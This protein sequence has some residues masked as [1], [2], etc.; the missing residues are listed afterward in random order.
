MTDAIASMSDSPPHRS[1]PAPAVTVIA[2]CYNHARFLMAC[3]ESIRAQT[4]QDFQLIVTDDC[5]KDDSP[6]MIAAWLAEFYPHAIFIRHAKNAGICATLNEAV[7]LAQGHFISMIATDDTWQ[8]HKIAAQ[9]AVAMA[10][11]ENTAVVYSDALQMDEE[12]ALLEGTFIGSHKKNF[13]APGGAVFRQLADGNFIPAMA[14]L[15][16]TSA[17]RAV[18][19]YDERLSYEDYD[20]WLRLANRYDFVFLPGTVASYRIVATSIVRTL[21]EKPTPRHSYSRFLIHEKWLATDRL[22][23]SQ[24]TIWGEKL[25]DSAYSLYALDDPRAGNCLWKAFFATRKL[26]PL[27]LAGTTSLGLNR[28]RA[29]RMARLFRPTDA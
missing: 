10:Q 27:L 18:G 19:G 3:L 15:I 29:V 7:A 6:D 4:F 25:W 8:P 11:D 17:I 21:F 26:R 16:R 5:S 13:D 20:M 24:K 28:T 23:T 22:S 9:H 1:S 14:T 2:L 12:G